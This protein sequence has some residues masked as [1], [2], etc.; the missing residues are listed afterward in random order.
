MFVGV[1]QIELHVPASRSLKAKRSVM[2]SVK[3]KVS[4]LG[5]H[6]SEV[7]DQDLWQSG[8]LGA[9]AVSGSPAFLDELTAKIESACLREPRAL[10]LRV[11]ARVFPVEWEA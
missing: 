2:A 8:I 1:Y 3:A 6:I 9:S 7:E 4:K 10:L 5:V 11:R